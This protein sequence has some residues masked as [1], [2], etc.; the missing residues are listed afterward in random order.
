MRSPRELRTHIVSESAEGGPVFVE[1]QASMLS[2]M[3]K[4]IRRYESKLHPSV[5][6]GW[7]CW[8]PGGR[9]CR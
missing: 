1:M 2:G 8:P 4:Q 5:A 3:P 9:R 6:A 7:S